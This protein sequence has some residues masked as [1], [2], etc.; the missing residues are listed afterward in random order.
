MNIIEI[1]LLIII[2]IWFIIILIIMLKHDMIDD[3]PLCY[4]DETKES[5]GTC[6]G[7]GCSMKHSCKSY[8]NYLND[9]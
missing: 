9:N 2:G 7:D 4:I 1:L 6:T 5:K 3:A 8:Q